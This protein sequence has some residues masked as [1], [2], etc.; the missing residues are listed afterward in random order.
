MLDFDKDAPPPQTTVAA[1]RQMWEIVQIKHA[2]GCE[3]H[4]TP[5][6]D[7]FRKTYSNGGAEFA[8]FDVVGNSDFKFFMA[9]H[10]WD[11]IELPENVLK[12]RAFTEALPMFGQGQINDSFG[13]KR[14]SEFTFAGE[15]AETLAIGGAYDAHSKGAADA[16]RTAEEFRN[17]LFGD[18][19]DDMLVLWSAKAWCSWFCDVA[20]D[21]TWLFVDKRR[22]QVSILAV[23][24]TD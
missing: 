19:F 4:A 11:L 6:L 18:R 8:V 16:Y 5:L 21:Q 22:S 3:H 9:T 1:L 23:T 24:D 2:T 17:S 12:S 20:W 13:F 14:S 7:A 10:S 15:I